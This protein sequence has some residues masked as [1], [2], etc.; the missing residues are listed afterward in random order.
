[1]H[2]D[3]QELG[4]TRRELVLLKTAWDMSVLVDTVFDAWRVTLWADIDAESMLDETKKLQTQVR[5]L[6]A[7]LR[8]WNVC[9][10]VE[11][12]LREMATIMPLVLDLR[13]PAMQ[14]RHWKHI[15]SVTHSMLEK[16]P[17]FSLDD[18]LSMK[19]HKHVAD[20]QEVVEV[21]N[22][23]LK[24]ERKLRTIEDKWN[25]FTLEFVPYKDMDMKVLSPPDEVIETLEDHMLQLQTMLGMGK[26]VEYF[27]AKVQAWQDTLSTVETTLMTWLLVQR[28]WVALE[29][30]FL[31]SKDIRSQLPEDSK[32]F[33]GIDQD[34]KDLM[35]EAVVDPTVTGACTVDGR[36]D[37][38][39][40]MV[41]LL[42]RCEKALNECVCA[43]RGL[44]VCSVSTHSGLWFDILQ[45]PGREEEH[46][47]AVLLCGEHCA[48]PHPQQRQR[49][50]GH[51][52]A[53][54]FLL[55]RCLRPEACSLP[56][57]AT[58]SRTS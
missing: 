19:L 11:D 2:T 20:V 50:A 24:I 56:A 6:P 39:A 3:Y 18:L 38:L 1:M 33:E 41:V 48:A 16:G 58:A 40:G 7:K 32:R 47:P 17:D 30:I 22:K 37:R 34:F 15:M 28:K 5:R 43:W 57:G 26:F 9:R 14:E 23:E 29:A 35:R 44:S 21:A 55:R 12:R 27:R 45:V 36:A 4:D 53:F 13:S 42:E 10:A 31:S 25:S 49:P 8:S 51:H 46:L 54:G 52:A